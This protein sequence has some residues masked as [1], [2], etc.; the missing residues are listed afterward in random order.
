MTTGKRCTL[1]LLL[2]L[3]APCAAAEEITPCEVAGEALVPGEA[4]PV[5]ADDPRSVLHRIRE[6][7]IALELERV[8]AAIEAFLARPDLDPVMRAEVVVLR[9]QAHVAFGDLDAAEQDYREIL[10]M[11]PEFVPDLSLTPQKGMERFQRARAATVGDVVIDVEPA[12]ARLEIDGR[13]VTLPAGGKLPM[14]AGEHQVRAERKGFDPVQQTVQVE[15][16]RDGRIELRLVPNSR[17]VVIVTEP[18]GV[19]VMLDGVWVGRTSRA[20]GAN[21]WTARS[22]ARLVLEDLPLGEHLFELALE[23]HRTEQLRDLLTVDLLDWRPKVY[24]LKRMLPVSSTALLREGPAGADV[25]IDGRPVGRLPSGPIEVCPGQRRFEVRQADRVLWSAVETLED[26]EERVLRVEP[27]PNVL[28]LGE[29]RWPAELG[30]LESCCN[31]AIDGATPLRGDLS[32]P[33]SWA[34]LRLRRDVDLV[35]ARREGAEGEPRWWL[36]S[37]WL[38]SVAPF[39]PADAGHDR[40]SWT[41]VVWGLSLVDSR[42]SGPAVV[43]RLTENGGAAAAGLQVGDRLTSLGGAQIDSASQARRILGLASAA[44]PLEAEW[45]SPTGAARRG[46]LQGSVGPRL[47][48]YDGQPVAAAFRAG[49]AV[50]DAAAGA[51]GAASATA[52]LGLLLSAFGQHEAAAQAWRR[53]RLPE[54]DGIG[55]GTIMYYLGRDLAGLGSER[56]AVDAL[57]QAAASEATVF[58]D[59]GPRVAPAARDRLADLGVR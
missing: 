1:W 34:G 32:R 55:R 10:R 37:P 28:L 57:K 59:D 18:E 31:S 7:L 23:C 3:L 58:D 40:P 21:E 42:R 14:V 50:V 36:Y 43:A 29:E 17:T 51:D 54:R 6:D 33:A 38:R 46:R 5:D 48:G 24:P 2:A 35:L 16:N 26:A 15:A 27:R 49:W 25:L 20:A 56:E 39:D 41:G 4:E 30:P 47:T 12:D 44:A 19:N 22:P 45:L 9:S 8:L 53:V 52:N 13:E 11:R